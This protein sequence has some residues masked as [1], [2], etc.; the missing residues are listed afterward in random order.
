MNKI[1][2]NESYI[3]ITTVDELANIPRQIRVIKRMNNKM[4]DAVFGIDFAFNCEVNIYVL[5]GKTH[6][7][8]GRIVI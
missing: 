2:H 5:C 7:N 4:I 1:L 6:S 8:S 3:I